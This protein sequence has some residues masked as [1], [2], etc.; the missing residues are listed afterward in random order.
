M[1]PLA[2]LRLKASLFSAACLTMFVCLASSPAQSI[3]FREQIAPILVQRCLACHG[4]LKFQGEYQLHN[5]EAMLKAGESGEAAVTPGKPEESY[6]LQLISASDAGERMPKDVAP[7]S[8]AE[9]AAIRQWIAAGAVFDGDDPQAELVS[10]VVWKHPEPPA[11]YPRPLPITALAFRPD[12]QELAVSGLHEI[13]IWNTADGVLARR[14]ANAA[15]RTYSLAY[16]ADGKLL[17]AAGGTPGRLGEIKVFDPVEGKLLRH[18]GSM[19]DCAFD[20]AF[21]PD[22]AKLAGCGADH[23]VRIWDASTGK[24]ELVLK[25]HSDWVMAVAWSPDGVRLATASRDRTC[26]VFDAL[27]GQLLLTY[28]DHGQTV[29]DVAFSSDGAR[30]VS[31]GADQRIR[32]WHA[33]DQGYEDKEMKKKKREHIHEI[34]GFGGEIFCLRMDQQ[35]VFAGS[36][37]A[38]VRQYDADKRNQLQLYAGHQEWVYALDYCPSARLLATG[39]LDG[40]IR[41]WNT[42]E[43]DENKRNIATFF[44]A[45]G[46]PSPAQNAPAGTEVKP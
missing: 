22:G 12:G 16:S 5:F 23:A 24:S 25:D 37:D 42:A 46:Y 9:I 3:S 15:E 10:S 27:S 43:V 32:V 1:L 13:T 4:E 19:T 34:S 41:I 29:H 31:A 38:S 8:T 39:S 35:R 36:A 40:Q 20:V 17:A 26:K 45:P 11:A 21:S 2:D 7:L 14:I 18:F 30:V 44:A 6:L 33:N 28:S